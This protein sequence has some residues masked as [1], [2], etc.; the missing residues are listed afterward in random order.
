MSSISDYLADDHQRC[1]RFFADAEA[2]VADG[3]WDKAAAGFQTFHAAIERHLSMEEELLF[4]TFE[5]A[6]GMMG[7]PTDVMRME[8]EQ[9]RA[10]FGSMAGAVAAHD[11]DSYLGDAETLLILMQQHN[12]KEEQILYPMFD[13]VL[14]AQS[15]ELI[16]QLE[17]R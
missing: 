17:H 6:T 12:A 1:D 10:L 4:P 3:A 16:D 13:Q 2:Q 7:G 8:H 9:M 11:G 5:Q 14:G 15:S